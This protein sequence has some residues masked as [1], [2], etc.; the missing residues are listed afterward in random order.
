MSGAGSGHPVGCR[1]VEEKRFR[2]SLAAG[3]FLPPC[4]WN[5][6]LAVVG[7]GAGKTKATFHVVGK[8]NVPGTVGYFDFLTFD[9]RSQRLYVSHGDQVVVLDPD[10][11]KVVTTLTGFKKVHG[12]A[13]AGG[14]AFVT[15]GATNLVRAF[16]TGNWTVMGEAQAGENPDAILYDPAS[17]QIFAFNHT[18]GSATVIDPRTIH[19]RKTISIP[20]KVEIGQADGKGTVWVNVEDKNE[21]VRIDSRKNEVTAHWPIT[22]CQT[23]T[24]LGFDAKNRRLFAGCEENNMMVV[25]DADSGK[26]IADLPI[27]GR[28]DGTEYD[29]KTGLIFNSC[30]DGTLTIIQQEGPDKYSV[31]QTVETM[32]GGKTLAYDRARSRVFV[33]AKVPESGGLVVLVIEP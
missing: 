4:C 14:R 3:L 32:K 15:D 13:L 28:V 16:D 23:P 7:E 6:S 2:G 26:V 22:P 9:E 27:G 31:L 33:P 12:I 20:G 30:A 11:G 21:I 25:V 10:S 5:R 18:G 1:D 19:V 8:L 24:G 29:A 17:R